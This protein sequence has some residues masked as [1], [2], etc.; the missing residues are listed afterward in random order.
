[1][2][3]LTV[4]FI[5]RRYPPSIGG[6][7]TYCKNLYD[8]LKRLA[9]VKLIAYR[10]SSNLLLPF[11]LFRAW[12][13]SLA[14][15]LFPGKSK[16]VLF[17]A[18]G[19]TAL[20]IPFLRPFLGGVNTTVT[21]YGLEVT[22]KNPVFRKLLRFALLSCTSI[23]TISRSSRDLIIKFGIP[24]D[25][26]KIIYPAVSVEDYSDTTLSHD[27]SEFS[28]KYGID[29]SRSPVILWLGRMVKRKGIEEFIKNGFPLL[30]NNIRFVICGNG[31]EKENI[32]KAI[33]DSP[34]SDRIKFA[35]EV[36]GPLS[37][38]LRKN[39]DIFIMPNIKISGDAEG[40]GLTVAEAFA[41]GLPVAAFAVDSLPEACG[42]A[43]FTAPQDDYEKLAEIINGY[44][45]LSEEDKEKIK[46][47]CIKHYQKISLPQKA[48]GEY[49][50]EFR[51]PG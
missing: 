15:C 33:N 22:Y 26:I 29:F 45:E 13:R 37:A 42:D 12:I 24:E 32:R 28:D 11:F 7:Q 41:A 9:R 40:Y 36:S 5:A 23:I 30:N 43:G 21:I 17:F 35:G 18:D 6:I 27:L 44:L 8:G 50:T 14:V 31:R 46:N 4:Y 51:R 20:L 3:D 38:A 10:A 1:M 25:K 39:S 16:R 34:H 19:V 48:A 2:E 49:L 47:K